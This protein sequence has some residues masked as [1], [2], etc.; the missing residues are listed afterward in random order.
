MNAIEFITWFESKITKLINSTDDANRSRIRK[1]VN[2]AINYLAHMS[3]MDRNE[4]R[5]LFYRSHS[6]FMIGNFKI[7]YDERYQFDTIEA[8]LATIEGY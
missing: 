4:V 8:I 1:L 3:P 2:E 7:P 6:T 5:D